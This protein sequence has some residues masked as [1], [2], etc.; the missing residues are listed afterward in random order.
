MEKQS[1]QSTSEIMQQY[2]NLYKQEFIGKILVDH[3]RLSMPV[4]GGV[5]VFVY[6]GILLVLH[7][8]AGHPLPSTLGDVF[9]NPSSY[10]Y[11]P[12]LI[13]VTYDLVANPLLIVLLMVFRDFIP[14]QFMQ[15]GRAH[16]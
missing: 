11:Y 1:N 10:F 12:N 5:F 9:K 2:L 7:S 14:R 3:L 15:I 8:I 16:V 6:F 13:G 4:I